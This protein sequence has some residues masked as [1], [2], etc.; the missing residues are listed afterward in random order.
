MG[1]AEDFANV[2]VRRLTINAVYWGL[3][4]EDSIRADRSVELV[5]EYHP[6]KSG[7]DYQEL[8]VQPH[9]PEYYK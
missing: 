2:G 1:S 3:G 6:S 9:K 7:F 8:G 5:G 4:M